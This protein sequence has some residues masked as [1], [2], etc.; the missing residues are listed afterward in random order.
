ML[1][2]L[3]VVRARKTGFARV[4]DSYATLQSLFVNLKRRAA[5]SVRTIMNG[6]YAA[7]ERRIVVLKSCGNA[8]DRCLYVGC[9][10]DE[11]SLVVAISD[12]TIQCANAGDAECA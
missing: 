12:Q 9:D 7:V 11:L 4:A 10:C 2:N 6:V 8:Y 3:P 1:C 5:D